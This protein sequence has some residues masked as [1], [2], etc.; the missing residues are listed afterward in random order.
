MKDE[1][2][3]RKTDGIITL[4]SGNDKKLKYLLAQHNH[5]YITKIDHWGLQNCC[6]NHKNKNGSN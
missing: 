3:G 1:G 6:W 2:K 5:V 4:D